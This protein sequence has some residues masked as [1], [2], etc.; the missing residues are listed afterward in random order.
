MG[1]QGE[2]RVLRALSDAARRERRPTA[3][4]VIGDPGSGKS[5]LLAEVIAASPMPV[6][7]VHGFEP[8]QGVPLAAVD[9]GD[10]GKRDVVNGVVDRCYTADGNPATSDDQN[11]GIR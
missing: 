2:L 11:P 1:R 6:E 4:L 9:S 3:A 8:T 7:R 10:P 5:R